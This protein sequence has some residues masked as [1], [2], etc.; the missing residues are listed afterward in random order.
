MSAPT[1][2][3]ESMRL[4]AA[5]NRN[6]REIAGREE[7]TNNELKRQKSAHETSVKNYEIAIAEANGATVQELENQK[8]IFEAALQSCEKEIVWRGMVTME[9]LKAKKA[10]LE[11]ADQELKTRK[12]R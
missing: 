7:T 4:I 11:V 9:K 12:E 10:Q 3:G 1:F 5:K 2:L 8:F 6:E